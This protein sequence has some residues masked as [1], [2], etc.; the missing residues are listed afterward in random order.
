[1]K[2]LFVLTIL[3]VLFFSHRSLAS[4]YNNG[5]N[6]GYNNN[7]NNGYN[8]GY[9]NNFNNGYN[10]CFNTTRDPQLPPTPESVPDNAIFS[11]FEIV[12]HGE[13]NWDFHCPRVSNSAGIRIENRS[14]DVNGISGY[15]N[16]T[17]VKSWEGIVMDTIYP[18]SDWIHSGIFSSAI[19]NSGQVVGSYKDNIL[20]NS[21]QGQAFIWQN[22]DLEIIS[23]P[24]CCNYKESAVDI[25]NS[26]YVAV[27]VANGKSYVWKDGLRFGLATPDYYFAFPQYIDDGLN[28]YGTAAQFVLEEGLLIQ[29]P[30]HNIHWKPIF[31]P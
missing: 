6:N 23:G 19:N 2:K 20:P 26:G 12:D 8:N 27:N 28:V 15:Q 17:D 7:Y 14:N 29:K 5:Y 25:N 9:N 3:F 31:I 16:V 30:S 10:N 4:E 18:P 22:G 13:G 1:M 24:I 11:G 21:A